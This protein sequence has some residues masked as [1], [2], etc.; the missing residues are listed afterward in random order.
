MIK[1][2]HTH[3]HTHTYTA[4]LKIIDTAQL[5]LK[6]IIW[7]HTLLILNVGEEVVAERDRAGIQVRVLIL[8]TKK[9]PRAGKTRS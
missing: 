9:F 2:T 7:P 8:L 5:N 3:T 6:V 4:K 1:R